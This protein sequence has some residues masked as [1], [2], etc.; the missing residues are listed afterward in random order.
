MGQGGLVD[1]LTSPLR[2]HG[3]GLGANTVHN[4]NLYFFFGDS[5]PQF[6]KPIGFI[7][8]VPSTGADPLQLAAFGTISC[9]R[10]TRSEP[11]L[12]P[13]PSSHPSLLGAAKDSW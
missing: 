5:G 8:G 7:P 9:R 3:D 2:R 12:I 13:L 10:S 4:D 6:S 11:R 1:P